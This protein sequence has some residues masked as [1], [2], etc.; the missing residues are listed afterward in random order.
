MSATVDVRAALDQAIERNI[1]R[2]AA[3]GSPSD[4]SLR[5][6]RAAIAELIEA[7][8]EYDAAREAMTAYLLSVT[9]TRPMT[10]TGLEERFN[11][12]DA[13]RAAALVRVQGEG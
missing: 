8:K 4:R 12:A 6:A 7:D 1:E 13:R 11:A 2:G 10:A 9:D 3:K 5:E